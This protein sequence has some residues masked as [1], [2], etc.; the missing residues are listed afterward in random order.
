MVKNPPA[1]QKTRVQ[2]LSQENPPEEENPMD[3]GAWQ[4]TVYRDSAT[5]TKGKG[6]RE[7]L[8]GGGWRG[9]SSYVRK[10]IL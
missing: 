4:A 1:I 2:S 5:T 8:I 10:G 7:L 9:I 3:R 6:S